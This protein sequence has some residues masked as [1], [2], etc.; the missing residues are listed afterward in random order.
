MDG[1]ETMNLK[2]L[3]SQQGRIVG[4]TFL[5]AIQFHISGFA[6]RKIAAIKRYSLITDELKI[7]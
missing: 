2:M 4:R 5:A 3:K 1:K 7:R 6:K